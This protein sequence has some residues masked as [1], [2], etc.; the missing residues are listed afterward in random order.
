MKPMGMTLVLIRSFSSDCVVP[1][2][3]IQST[4]GNRFTGSNVLVGH[5]TIL[6]LYYVYF[7]SHVIRLSLPL[8]VRILS[9]ST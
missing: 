9:A 4:L 6:R 7:P 3:P 2:V 8:V 5:N 1:R